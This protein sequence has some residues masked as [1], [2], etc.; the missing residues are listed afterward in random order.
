MKSFQE[1]I[2]EAMKGSAEAGARL[3]RIASD[4]VQEEQ[5][6]RRR[7]DRLNRQFDRLGEVA[8][9]VNDRIDYLRKEIADPEIPDRER[10][11]FLGW[12]QAYE[13]IRNKLGAMGA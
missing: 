10:S 5:R 8:T 3:G 11:R 6:I 1:E 13:E 4:L 2:A 7:E 9:Y 12:I